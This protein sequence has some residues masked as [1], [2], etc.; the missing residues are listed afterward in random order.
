MTKPIEF[1]GANIVFTA[2]GC[3]DVPALRDETGILWCVEL[4][5]AERARVFATGRVWIKYQ[6]QSF[7]P[8]MVLVDTT[9]KKGGAGGE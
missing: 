4:D 6:S 5:A 9:K 3:V 1:D 2:P 7:P 8:T